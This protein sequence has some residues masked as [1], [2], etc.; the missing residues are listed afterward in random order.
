[1]GVN[2]GLSQRMIDIWSESVARRILRMLYGPITDNDICRTR[3][4]NELYMLY[5]DLDV[6]KAIKT[7]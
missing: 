6:V 7:G 1:M 4:N 3:Y 2:A 5:D